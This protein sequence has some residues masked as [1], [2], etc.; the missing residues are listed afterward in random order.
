MYDFNTFVLCSYLV[1]CMNCLVHNL[2][3]DETLDTPPPIANRTRRNIAMFRHHLQR[4]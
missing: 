2:P 1:K 4:N 3:C